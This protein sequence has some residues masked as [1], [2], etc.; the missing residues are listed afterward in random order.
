MNWQ[1][2]PGHLIPRV[3]R[4]HR[5]SFAGHVAVEYMVGAGLAAAAVVLGFSQATL[6]AALA[7]GVLLASSAAGTTISSGR[8]YL[9]KSWDRVLVYLLSAVTLASAIAAAGVDTLVFA[10]ATLI[11][12][13]LLAITHYVP[14]R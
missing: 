5:L 9:H 11:E 2:P 14:E 6:L 10:A 13:I 3:A 4:S 12:A 1:P 8:I 7:L